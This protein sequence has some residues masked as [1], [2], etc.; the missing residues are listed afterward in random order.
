M[1]HVEHFANP[2]QRSRAT[3][4]E[5]IKQ[6]KATSSYPERA[7]IIINDAPHGPEIL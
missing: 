1:W 4:Y 3:F 5:V 2:L 6:D 7:I